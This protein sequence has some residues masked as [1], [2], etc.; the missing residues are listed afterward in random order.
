MKRN[1]WSGAELGQEPWGCFR[2]ATVVLGVLLIVANVALRVWRHGRDYWGWG[3]EQVEFSV[4]LNDGMLALVNPGTLPEEDARAWTLAGKAAQEV[5]GPAEQRPDGTPLMVRV[6]WKWEPVLG[7]PTVLGESRGGEVTVW[8]S[9]TDA[10]KNAFRAGHECGHAVAAWRYGEGR[11]PLWAEEGLAQ[12]A[13]FRAA[14][15]FARVTKRSAARIPPD[16]GD[17]WPHLAD[18]LARRDYPTDPDA[19]AVFYWQSAALVRVLS[20]RLGPAHFR[21]FFDALAGGADPAALLR[22]RYWFSDA[23][24]E[25]LDRFIQPDPPSLPASAA[26]TL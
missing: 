1:W 10:V 16:P 6:V 14:D 25:S 12:L 17:G 3:T 26:W 13:G 4:C 21:D 20:A 2:R 22:E 15:E 11:L 8:A 7:S 24:L 9:R 18:L 5:V 23:D 19:V